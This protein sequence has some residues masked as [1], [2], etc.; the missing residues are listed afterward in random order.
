MDFARRRHA[1]RSGHHHIEK[2]E[3]EA[4]LPRRLQKLPGVMKQVQTDGRALLLLPCAQKRLNG[5]QFL[6]L[7]VAYRNVHSLTPLFRQNFSLSNIL[8]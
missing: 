8:A 4:L 2:V 1:A 3:C 5:F 7:V 6:E